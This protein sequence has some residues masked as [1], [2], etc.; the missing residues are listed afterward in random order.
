MSLSDPHTARSH[1]LA[2]GLAL[3]ALMGFGTLIIGDAATRW[4]MF[5]LVLV[6]V[7]VVWTLIRD[8]RAALGATFILTLQAEM[9][10]RFMYGRDRTGGFEL[11]LSSFAAAAVY[12]WMRASGDTIEPF[13]TLRRPILL[14]F[15]T[16]CAS[17]LLSHDH[18]V[19]SA[20][21]LVE[22]QLLLT[23]IVALNF[24]RDERTVRRVVALLTL[25]LVIQSVVYVIQSQLGIN[26]NLTGDVVSAGEVPRPGGTVSAN[27]A[28]FAS[29]IIP[30]LLINVAALGLPRSERRWYVPGVVLL[31]LIAVV[32]TFTRAAWAGLAIALVFL[33][34]FGRKSMQLKSG[35][36]GAVIGAGA[37]AIVVAWPL[38]ASRLEQSSVSDAY[39]E[40]SGL[41]RIAIEVIKHNPILGVG[42]GAYAARFKEY[43]PPG[44]GQQWLFTVHNEFLLRAAETGL[45]GGFA[46]VWL[47]VA[48]LKQAMALAR[49]YGRTPMG[50]VAAGWA[51]GLV[52]IAWQMYWV[53]WRGFT[54]TALF[55]F[56]LGLTE[57][58]ARLAAHEQSPAG[59]VADPVGATPAS[60][61]MGEVA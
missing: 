60:I 55:W 31:G 61:R 56:M 20:R 57:A 14:L 49:R 7:F 16:T 44:L 21:V 17:A 52:Y 32:L 24:V 58:M 51:A 25:A 15:A 47:M 5:S 13:G 19:S 12:L 28:G 36:L 53:P 27:P 29:F 9:A 34:W 43:I 54:Y 40:R 11:F 22:L 2:W 1:S 23:Y 10:I 45:V 8:R 50:A 30:I 3:G 18:F 33:G 41:N 4:M 37:I 35:R 59:L 46:F 39:K 38:M 48:A 42:P 26:F 6:I